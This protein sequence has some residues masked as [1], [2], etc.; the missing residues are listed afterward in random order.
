MLLSYPESSHSKEYALNKLVLTKSLK[1]YSESLKYNYII[2]IFSAK[3]RFVGLLINKKKKEKQTI[4]NPVIIGCS[5]SC[6]VRPVKATWVW[7]SFDFNIAII[8]CSSC[9]LVGPVKATWAC[10]SFD[11][12]LVTMSCSTYCL[13]RPAKA[14][15]VCA[16][17]CSNLFIISC[18]TCCL[19]RPV[20]ATWVCAS[21][22]SN[23]VDDD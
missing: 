5:T 7:A 22:D 12:N 6:L 2:N 3:T 14:T 23:L 8:S 15:W 16:S 11:S 19:V 4:F 13:A 1:M 21:F 10:A 17:F 9:C 20:K 18:S